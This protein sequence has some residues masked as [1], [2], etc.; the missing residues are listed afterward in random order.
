MKKIIISFLAV[1]TFLSIA[2]SA[3]ANFFIDAAGLWGHSWSEREGENSEGE[4]RLWGGGL[5]FGIYLD[6]QVTI[7]LSG[8]YVY[9]MGL[10]PKEAAGATSS[11]IY[12]HV[13]LDFIPY[14]SFLNENRIFWI[15]SISAGIISMDVNIDNSYVQYEESIRGIQFILSTGILY[16]FT[17]HIAPYITVGYNRMAFFGKW[18][19]SSADTLTVNVGV[20]FFLFSPHSINQ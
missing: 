18:E 8:G 16:Q 10:T 14:F 7:K 12:T 3:S 9:G 19:G 17:Q 20:R 1:I 5:S 13:G 4:D 15:S 2:E 11:M 6:R